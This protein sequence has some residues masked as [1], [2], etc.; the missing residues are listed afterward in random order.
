MKRIRFEYDVFTVV[1]FS[2]E[3]MIALC[4]MCRAHYDSQVQAM[5]RYLFWE[6]ASGKEEIK[7]SYRQLDTLCKVTEQA[8]DERDRKTRQVDAANEREIKTVLAGLLREASAE[9]ARMNAIEKP[10][11][12]IRAERDD[13]GVPIVR[14]PQFIVDMLKVPPHTVSITVRTIPGQENLFEFGCEWIEQ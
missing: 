1:E 14:V 12:W 9:R 2:R 13:D 6:G 8:V 4:E 11:K 3:E 10:G 7:L 5:A